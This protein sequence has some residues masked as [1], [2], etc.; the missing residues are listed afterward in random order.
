[1]PV[2][3]KKEIQL[4]LLRNIILNNSNFYITEIRMSFMLIQLS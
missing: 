3:L 1:M 4:V 2:R